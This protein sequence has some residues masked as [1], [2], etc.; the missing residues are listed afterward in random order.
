MTSHIIDCGK[1]PFG[2]AGETERGESPL[3]TLIT[4]TC[5]K[6][7][8]LCEGKQ[9]PRGFYPVYESCGIIPQ[10]HA[11]L[12]TGPIDD[13][14]QRLVSECTTSMLRE[15]RLKVHAILLIWGKDRRNGVMHKLR[16]A[17]TGTLLVTTIGQIGRRRLT[18]NCV[19]QKA[20]NRDETSQFRGV[21]ILMHPRDPAQSVRQRDSS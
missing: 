17:K 7:P 21:A 20:V 16:H 13:L 1:W 9:I 18:L 4:Q 11:R 2:L 14:K 10:W 15:V 3:A 19:C 8:E 12:A 5:D 6:T